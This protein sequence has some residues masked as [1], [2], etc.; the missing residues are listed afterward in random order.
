MESEELTSALMEMETET[1]KNILLNPVLEKFPL[2]NTCITACNHCGKRLLQF[3]ADVHLHEYHS[4]A[5]SNDTDDG[6]MDRMKEEG[7]V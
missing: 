4:G 7:A 6:I 1:N 3:A 2:I 5:M